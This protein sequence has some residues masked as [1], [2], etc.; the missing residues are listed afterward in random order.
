M[1]KKVLLICLIA[2]AALLSAERLIAPDELPEYAK[3]FIQKNFPNS[4]IKSVEEDDDEYG[5]RLNTGESLE[6]DMEGNFEQAKFKRGL[7]S[8]ILPK[9]AADYITLTYPSVNIVK[10]ELKRNH[11]EVTLRNKMELIFSINGDF[12]NSKWDT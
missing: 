11:Y 6:F 4:K 12:I 3:E 10:I 8:S 1:K 9:T 7:P 5:V 2:F